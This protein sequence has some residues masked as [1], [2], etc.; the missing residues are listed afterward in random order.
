MTKK[1]VKGKDKKRQQRAS[2]QDDG[3]TEVVRAQKRLASALADLDAARDKVARRERDLGSLMQ[4]Y[5]PAESGDV[6]E[7]VAIPLDGPTQPVSA[8]GVEHEA[9]ESVDAEPAEESGEQSTAPNVDQQH[10]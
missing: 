9:A 4:R 2:N 1:S 8:N 6:L 10:G 3:A 5:R 7:D